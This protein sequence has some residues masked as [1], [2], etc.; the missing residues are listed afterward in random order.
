M[1][2]LTNIHI[3]NICAFNTVD[4]SPAQGQ[5]TLIFGKNLDNDAQ[6]SNGSGKSALLEAIAIGITGDPLRKVTIE[7]I[8][9]DA[10][11]SANIQLS[12][13]STDRSQSFVIKRLLER[14]E[15][16]RIQVELN[17]ATVPQANINEYNRYILDTLGLRKSDIFS[18]FILSRH[19]YVSF[20]NAPDRDKKDLINRFCNGDLV[21]ESLEVLKADIESARKEVTSS[22]LKVSNISGA[23]SALEDQI[24]EYQEEFQNKEA[25]RLEIIEAHKESIIKYRGLIRTSHQICESIQ[26][27]LK[28][29]DSLDE[30]LRDL[31]VTNIS[32]VDAYEQIQALLSKYSLNNIKDYIKFSASIEQELAT[33][34]EQI[35]ESIETT[36]RLKE[37]HDKIG[38]AYYSLNESYETGVEKRKIDRKHLDEEISQ[39]KDAISTFEGDHKGLTQKVATLTMEA[40]ELDK[41]LLGVIQCPNCSHEFVVGVNKSVHALRRRHTVVMKELVNLRAKEQDYLMRIE[42]ADAKID[43]NQAEIKK[44]DDYS[45]NALAEI[46]RLSAKHSELN[47]EL[48]QAR[49]KQ[50]DLQMTVDQAKKKLRFIR[51]SM[52]DDAFQLID[53]TGKQLECD[54]EAETGKIQSFYGSIES[55]EHA[56]K[57]MENETIELT[58]SSIEE[59]L[60]KA[61][62]EKA[63]ASEE[64]ERLSLKLSELEAQAVRFSDFKTHL[65]NS[66]IEA[67]AEM[68][69]GFLEAIGSDITIALSG[70]TTLRSG[71][72]R[73]KISITVKRNGVDCGSFSKMSQG[74]QS[75]VNLANILALNKLT[76]MNCPELRGLDLLV[77]DE[78]LD[79]TDEAGLANM[80][81]ALNSLKITTLVVSHSQVAENYPH[82]LTILKQN[83]VSK[84]LNEENK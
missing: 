19:R 14:G 45:F 18:S 41:S 39:L 33:T 16:Q 72:V 38:K 12:F 42:A 30:E 10:A 55:Y 80:F 82:R 63:A 5:T 76:N 52:F 23:V 40:A 56:L 57:Q 77:L 43:K 67:L 51:Q 47:L 65:A 37:E 61:Q 79:A 22:N 28:A 29:I 60:R 64:F 68:T 20:L 48:S 58:V 71:K 34:M 59:K 66:K 13:S 36:R 62:V 32:F 44:I 9:N 31:E 54:L 73:E 53:V 25:R 8:I 81:E 83:G 78:I 6:G 24:R 74:E 69:N 4:F 15:S 21:D 2:R 26:D 49:M 75:R 7:E 11:Q 27:R 70:Y 84:L 46:R 17:G 1:W 35:D 3:E 50:S